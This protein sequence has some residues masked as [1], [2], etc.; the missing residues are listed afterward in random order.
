MF[1]WIAYIMNNGFPLELPSY[2][3]N[4]VTEGYRDFGLDMA[5]LQKAFAYTLEGLKKKRKHSW[6]TE[7]FL[8]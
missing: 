2:Y 5:I 1:L 3:C 4:V 6:E 8:R 7:W